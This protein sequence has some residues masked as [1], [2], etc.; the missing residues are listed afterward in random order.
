MTPRPSLRARHAGSRTRPG[1]CGRLA[2][3][4]LALQTVPPLEWILVENGSSDDT[5]EVAA[6]LAAGTPGFA[7]CI[8]TSRGET[9]RGGAIVR[10]FGAGSRRSRAGP[11]WS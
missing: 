6:A 4:L 2:E 3:C 11:T 10:A 8:T 5:P 9:V 1:T 7:S